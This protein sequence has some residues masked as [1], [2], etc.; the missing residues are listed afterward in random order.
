MPRALV[1]QHVAH[2]GP[3]RI[4][5]ALRA[6]GLDIDLRRVDRG[7]AIPATGEGFAITVVL[8]GPM[9]VGDL[10]KPGFAHLAA[11]V[12]LIRTLILAERPFLGVCLGAQL[13][14]HAA[15][16]RVYKNPAGTEVGW[17]PLTLHGDGP[18]RTALPPAFPVLH[19]HSDTFDLPIGARHVAST[20]R[21]RHQA[22][23]LGTLVGVQFHAEAEP[24]DI[25]AMIAHDGP[26]ITGALGPAAAAIIHSDTERFIAEHRRHGDQLIANILAVA[27][28]ARRQV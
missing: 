3:G 11:E 21:C 16:A 2:E 17:A 22:F 5:V 13:L 23:H 1:I 28:N 14:A 25:A 15:G 18:L 19:W 27:G 6:A 12:A 10:G 8:G 24:E 9:G 4:G 7:D 26:Y 20:P